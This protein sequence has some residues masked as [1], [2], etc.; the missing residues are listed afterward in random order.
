MT[1]ATATATATATAMEMA[2]DACNQSAVAT[3]HKTRRR[4]AFRGAEYIEYDADAA[5][6]VRRCG[7][8]RELQVVVDT[9]ADGVRR[10]RLVVKGDAEALERERRARLLPP[11]KDDDAEEEEEEEED[12]AHSDDD[13]SDMQVEH[14]DSHGDADN[15]LEAALE[16][17]AEQA[18]AAVYEREMR[19]TLAER[20]FP[21]VDD[22][23]CD[24]ATQLQLSELL[25]AWSVI[26]GEREAREIVEHGD[27]VPPSLD[28]D[29]PLAQQLER[30]E[31]CRKAVDAPLVEGYAFGRRFFSVDAFLSTLPEHEL[32]ELAER[33]ALPPVE[34]PADVRA[35][36]KVPESEL[37]A[38]RSWSCR[39]KPLRQLTF[40][41]V[42]EEAYAWGI[43]LAEDAKDA[44]L[45]KTKKAWVQRLRPVLR[46][47]VQLARET[48]I[49]AG[50]VQEQLE[51]T[52]EDA[53]KKTRFALIVAQLREL[54]AAHDA[55]PPP[56]PPA[57]QRKAE[58]RQLVLRY[59]R[60]LVAHADAQESDE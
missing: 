23:V 21:C 27:L 37:V 42:V 51:E 13:G 1:M 25:V 8:G 7:H 46:A 15:Q 38:M 36:I 2:A 39:G 47:A 19:A 5:P 40:R 29:A 57:D 4:L 17:P 33:N 22:A 59:F 50:I 55:T 54:L 30:L 58:H 6:V 18:L 24:V 9:D 43:D 12:N 56:P 3:G 48:E 45:K 31:L 53:M 34:L 32:F 52:L 35:F 26:A 11:A 14:E 44:K 49:R 10:R 16:G 60:A 20:G 41:E 28:V